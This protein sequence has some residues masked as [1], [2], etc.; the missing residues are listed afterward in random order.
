MDNFNEL[1]ENFR[2]SL[3]QISETSARY[4]LTIL[5]SEL[6]G[7]SSKHAEDAEQTYID[8]LEVSLNAQ[9]ALLDYAEGV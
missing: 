7:V 1:R 9:G 4:A 5:E 6:T 3:M 2:K 8:A